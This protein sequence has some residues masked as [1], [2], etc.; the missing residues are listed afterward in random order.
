MDPEQKTARGYIVV[1]AKGTTTLASY[2]EGAFSPSQ[3][4]VLDYTKGETFGVSRFRE[5]RATFKA[6]AFEG[7]KPRFQVLLFASDGRVIN[8]LHVESAGGG[9]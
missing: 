7:Q 9:G 6:A 1:L 5:A 8:N 2:P 3:N 4:I